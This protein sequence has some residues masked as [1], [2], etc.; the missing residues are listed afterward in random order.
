MSVNNHLSR[1]SPEFRQEQ[2]YHRI[3]FEHSPI[4]VALCRMNG[5]LVEVNPAFA[6][7][8]GRTVEETLRLCILLE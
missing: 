7:I 8:I 5:E 4:G 2:D 1:I 3:L 6:K